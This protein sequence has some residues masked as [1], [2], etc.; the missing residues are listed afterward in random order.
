[1]QKSREEKMR[2]RKELKEVRQ[3]GEKEDERSK[4][5]M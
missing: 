1:M 3:R 5:R 4:K 2:C